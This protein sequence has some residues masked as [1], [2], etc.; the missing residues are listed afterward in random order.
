MNNSDQI[1]KT[2]KTPLAA[3]LV[4]LGY[5]IVDIIYE[6]KIGHYLFANDDATLDAA[7]KDFELLRATAPAAQLISNYQF[8]ANNPCKF[9]LDCNQKLVV[10]FSQKLINISGF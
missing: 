6:G 10:N 2:N 9:C 7:I 8:I 1:R 5:S 4:T 3:Y